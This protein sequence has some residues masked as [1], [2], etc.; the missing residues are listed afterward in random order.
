MSI[1]VEK[2][3]DTFDDAPTIPGYTTGKTF[4][5]KKG[6]ITIDHI[7]Y[8]YHTGKDKT[9]AVFTD[10]SVSIQGGKK[11][12][13][14]GPSG[15]GK[16]TLVK[17]IAGYIHTN[18]GAIMVDNQILPSTNTKNHISLESYYKHVGYL[19][20]EPSVFDGTIRENL[21]YG[22]TE[23]IEEKDIEKALDLAECDFVDTLTNG[24]ETIIGEK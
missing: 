6:D 22:T 2:L 13:L 1:F 11:T 4:T 12:A 20:Q 16:S 18:T 17:L 19:T 9:E 3:R 10:F 24:L 7:T 21:L 15:S 23:N 14:V 5:F 8:T